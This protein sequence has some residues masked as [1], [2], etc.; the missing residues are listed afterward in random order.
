[1]FGYSF[2]IKTLETIKNRNIFSWKDKDIKIKI[3]LY[4]E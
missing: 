2:S 1:V 3:N 4:L